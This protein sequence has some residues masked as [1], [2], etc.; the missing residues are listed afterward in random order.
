MTTKLVEGV[1]IGKLPD[2]FPGLLNENK[3][4]KVKSNSDLNEEYVKLYNALEKT[5]IDMREINKNEIINGRIIK[6]SGN[7][8]IVDFG[9]KDYIFVEMPRNDLAKDLEEG[10]LIDVMITEVQDHPFLI[11]GSITELIKAN[12]HNK[13]KKYF[14]EKLPLTAKIKELIPAGYMLDIYMDNITIDA[15]MPNTLA[16]VNKLSDPE[17][18]LGQTLNVML[19]TL[20]QEK[21]VYVVSRRK[22][23]KTLIPEEIKKLKRD[24]IYTGEVTGTTPFG[25]FVQFNGCLTGMIHK[26]NVSEVWQNKWEEILPGMQ[27]DFYIKEITK[28][29]KIIL[30]QMLKESLWDKIK[31][32]KIL[33]GKVIDIKNFGAL[34]SLD[35]ETMGLIQTTYLVNN[36]AKLNKGDE[37]KVKVISVIKYDRKIYLNIVN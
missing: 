15:F 29:K 10:D 2:P 34:I 3:I 20:Q 26:M 5:F 30:T 9:Y 37:V 27:I 31:V 36:N 12:V 17:S 19:E 25:I 18:L 16:D 7:E 24:I 11:K 35:Y 4:Y 8:I 6:K 14:L 32:G 33:T 22:Y 21:G 13:L 28:T 23:L 1:N